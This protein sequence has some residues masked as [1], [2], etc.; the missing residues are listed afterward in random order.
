MLIVADRGHAAIKLIDAATGAGRGTW[1]CA[2]GFGTGANFKGVPFG[3]RTLVHKGRDMVLIAS[4][5]NPQV[6]ITS[7]DV[8]ARLRAN[9]IASTVAIC[10]T[11]VDVLG[12]AGPS[13]CLR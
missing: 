5:D 10:H 12:S 6:N 7:F 11:R 8:E 1:N 3:V 2:L 4:M 13:L 9:P